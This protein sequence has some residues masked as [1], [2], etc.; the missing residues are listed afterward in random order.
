MGKLARNRK[1]TEMLFDFWA[2]LVFAIV[3]ILIFLLF[4]ATKGDN[5]E[6]EIVGEFQEKDTQ[7]ML[8]SYL[9]APYLKDGSKTNAQII[10]EDYLDK[11][12][13]RT[14]ESFRAFFKGVL[15]TNNNP[16][17]G[18]GIA[19]FP[20]G[21]TRADFVLMAQTQNPKFIDA[22]DESLLMNMNNPGGIPVGRIL[23]FIGG[24]N[25]NPLFVSGANA[26]IPLQIEDS[27]DVSLYLGY[28]Q[29]E[30]KLFA[31]D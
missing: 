15:T 1:G 16:I 6:S 21:S 18:I 24:K 9:R 23:K 25:D 12:F 28:G 2:I 14:E 29:D 27:I 8:D 26:Q 17:G 10:A 3:M 13:S 11:D 22:V 20:S 5:K 7:Y 30:K 31:S 4:W 19:V